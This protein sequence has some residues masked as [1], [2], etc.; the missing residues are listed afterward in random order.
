M[1]IFKKNSTVEMPDFDQIMSQSISYSHTSEKIGGLAWISHS[2]ASRDITTGVNAFDQKFF[3]SNRTSY[4]AL[5][6]SQIN[7]NKLS[8][9]CSSN[10]AAQ[11]D[12]T[13][14]SGSQRH[15]SHKKSDSE[16]SAEKEYEEKNNA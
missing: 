10:L 12:T 1:Q 6:Q 7:M 9:Q 2:R 11:G 15:M 14:N 8:R 5:Q 4:T 13:N 3:Q 16:R